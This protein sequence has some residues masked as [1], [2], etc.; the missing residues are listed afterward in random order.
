MRV[1]VNLPGPFSVSTNV[2]P[3]GNGC[4]GCL[5]A[6]G[7]LVI[8]GLVLGVISEMVNHPA[9]IFT[10]LIVAGIIGLVVWLCI[11]LGERAN[12]TPRPPVPANAPYDRRL[13]NLDKYMLIGMGTVL[14]VA[15]VGTIIWS[16]LS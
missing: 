13:T 16:A 14:V 2:R 4:L 1:G 5:G 11:Y 9:T 3:S 6:I 15:I 7:V 12:R 10:F 8:V